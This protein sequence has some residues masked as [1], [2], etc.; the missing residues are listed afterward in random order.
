MSATAQ[1]LHETMAAKVDSVDKR[2]HAVDKEVAASLANLAAR[3]GTL[4]R[5]TWAIA[6][7]TLAIVTT[8][9]MALA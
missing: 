4:E 9:V 7:G 8:E 2:L 5:V 6:L 3:I 1:E